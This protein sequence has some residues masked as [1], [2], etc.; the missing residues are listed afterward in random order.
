MWGELALRVKG[1]P[2]SHLTGPQQCEGDAGSIVNAGELTLPLTEQ[3][4]GAGRGRV[5]GELPPDTTG[6]SSV[7]GCR[8]EKDSAAL[9]SL[10]LGI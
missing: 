1:E 6:L 4:S 5:T 7:D 9:R 8:K 3:H 10:P 2:V